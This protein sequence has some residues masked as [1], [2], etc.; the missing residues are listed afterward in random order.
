MQKIRKYI[1]SG[2]ATIGIIGLALLEHLPSKE[3]RHIEPVSFIDLNKDGTLD[4][5]VI[6]KQGREYTKGLNHYINYNSKLYKDG[7]KDCMMLNPLDHLTS[8][9]T[10]GYID[11][12]DIT[13]KEDKYFTR[14]K[15]TIIGNIDDFQVNKNN[16][17]FKLSENEK[18]LYVGRPGL[19]SYF[20][21]NQ[22]KEQ[23]AKT[24]SKR[25]QI[26]LQVQ[27]KQ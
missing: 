4:A 3:G 6:T 18:R 11:G 24:S 17:T 12:N 5:I 25:E 14:A 21:I 7:A 15:P 2:I 9:L 26:S 16:I 19:I 13:M 10:L 27:E 1:Y 23:P 22:S 20:E 8:Q